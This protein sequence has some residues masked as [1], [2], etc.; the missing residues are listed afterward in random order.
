M[1]L[2]ANRV[3]S[4]A[5]SATIKMAQ[6]GRELK[7]EGHDII[8][9]SLGEPDFATPDHIKEAAK[10][11][12]DAGFTKYTPVPGIPELRKAISDKFKR[13]NNLDY[14]P[15]QIV[16]STGAK[17]SLMNVFLAVVEPG[18]EVII[19]TPYWV[20]YAAM[21]H[22]A[23]AK[24]VNIEAGIDQDF[25]ITPEQLEAAITDKTKLFVFSSPCNPSGSVYSRAELEGLAEVFAK[26]PQIVIISDEI[27]ELINFEDK[28]E[29]IGSIASVK[30]QTV[31]VNG[32]SKGYSM[33]GWRIGYI[34]APLAIAK[35]CTKIQGQFTSGTCSIAQKAAVEAIS[36][37]QGP[38]HK[39]RETFLQR[40]GLILD[41]LSEIP[42]LETNTPPGAFYVFPNVS[43]YFGK[44]ADGETIKDADDLS[45]YLLKKAHVSTVSGAA[46][47]S[48][49]CIRISYATSNDM[50]EQAVARIKE[51]LA[52]LQ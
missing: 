35:A 24:M 41:L 30:D 45:M 19:P 23:E 38:S 6:L 14:S 52:K 42:G 28:H 16:V 26:H 22:M 46:F 1:E 18:E 10:A 2:L 51:A 25:K 29:S 31:T 17:Q 49:N 33:T 13:E 37:D 44:T 8:D 48:P 3:T 34:G 5:E 21:A 39:M 50:I 32:C 11:A 4:L 27:Y 40:R 15:D 9:L 20:S 36:G 47:G 43:A 7:A 12:V